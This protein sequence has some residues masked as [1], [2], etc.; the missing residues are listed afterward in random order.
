MVLFGI[1]L[2]SLALR[3]ECR[4]SR[5]YANRVLRRIFRKMRGEVTGGSEAA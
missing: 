2:G 3:K 5:V 4:R 1:K